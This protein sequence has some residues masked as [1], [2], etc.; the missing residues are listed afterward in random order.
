MNSTF[1]PALVAAQEFAVAV[2]AEVAD[3]DFLPRFGGVGTVRV[4]APARLISLALQL[5]ALVLMLPPG[6]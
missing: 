5:P 1:L 4:T 6:A 3:R 2:L